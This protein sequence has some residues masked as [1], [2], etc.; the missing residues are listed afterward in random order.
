MKKVINNYLACIIL[1]VVSLLAALLFAPIWNFW[2]GCPWKTWGMQILNILI[3]IVIVCY[4]ALFLFKKIK[5]SGKRV[6]KV[7]TIVEFA[8]LS[9]IAL[10]CVFSQF[11]IINISGACQIFALALWTIGCV[12]LFRAYYYRSDTKEVY[13]VWYLGLSIVMVSFGAYCFA[14]P[15]IQDIV[16]LWIFVAML[17]IL[18][19]L[20][21][22]LGF[23]NKTKKK[24]VTT[25]KSETKAKTTNKAK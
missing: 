19:L 5:G 24:S 20:L 15:F 18:G 17:A 9:L 3:A 13:P 7:L 25:N 1:G 11:K 8:L 6:I 10:G 22:V 23:N 14:R 21:L 4:L 12:E 16:I 2:E